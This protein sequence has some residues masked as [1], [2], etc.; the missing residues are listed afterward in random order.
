MAVNLEPRQS[1]TLI[2][3]TLRPTP[4]AIAKH[5]QGKTQPLKAINRNKLQRHNWQRFTI[6]VAQ[7]SAEVRTRLQLVDRAFR[8]TDI[9]GQ[10]QLL[11]L[12]VPGFIEELGVAG[13]S[14]SRVLDRQIDAYDSFEDVTNSILGNRVGPV[15]Y[16][17]TPPSIHRRCTLHSGWPDFTESSRTLLF[18]CLA[19][20]NWEPLKTARRELLDRTIFVGQHQVLRELAKHFKLHYLLIAHFADW[21]AVRAEV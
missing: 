2:K 1:T 10:G 15:P 9:K 19:K 8:A 6:D 14:V 17:L 18:C 11:F 13:D 12:G 21:I 7:S 16:K 20:G 3:R 4:L 5:N